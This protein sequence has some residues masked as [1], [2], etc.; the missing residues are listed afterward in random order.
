MNNTLLAFL[1]KEFTQAFR[2]PRMIVILFL[3]PIFQLVVFGIAIST[4]VKNIRLQ[5]FYPPHDTASQTL[6]RKAYGSGWF[7]PAEQGDNLTPYQLIESDKAD[8]VI[9]APE[10][11]L[12]QAIVRGAGELQLLINASNILYARG[13]DNYVQALAAETGNT[14]LMPISFANR[15]LYNP[16]LESP[17]Y[18]IPGILCMIACILTVMLTSI[19]ITKEKEVGTFELLIASPIKTW[20]ILLG[21]TLPYYIFGLM[22]MVLI[23]LAGFF[24]FGV[25][26]RGS[27]GALSISALFFI[28][29]TTCIGLL[30]ST[31]CRTQQQAMMSGFLFLFPAIMLSGII[32]P[33]KNMPYVLQLISY[34]NPLAYF[35][36]LVR[37]I[38]LKGDNFLLV[39]K[40][41]IILMLIALTTISISVKRFKMSLE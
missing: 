30:I 24:I 12:T 35:A 14:A 11:G 33:L 15:V 19:S 3:I 2:D 36:S 41:T 34:I 8:A 27:I 20:E 31:F 28:A 32:S 22:S 23:V 29:T 39:T 26:L 37:L 1:K 16:N 6:E 5:C 17:I 9:V 18:M 40:Y 7:I 25:P 10:G 4:E 38:M 13:I 21:K